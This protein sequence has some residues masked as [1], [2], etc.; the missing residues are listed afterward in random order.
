MDKTRIAHHY[1]ILD[2]EKV[3]RRYIEAHQAMKEALELYLEA[4]IYLNGE[5]EEK[6]PILKRARTLGYKALN[7]THSEKVED[8]THLINQVRHLHD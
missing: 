6:V 5:M 8:I 1:D 4:S 2:E 3:A 7:L